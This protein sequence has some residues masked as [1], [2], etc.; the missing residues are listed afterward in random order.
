VA[1]AQLQARGVS[2]KYGA[3]AGVRPAPPGGS[4]ESAFREEVSPRPRSGPEAA[5]VAV[6]TAI[7]SSA[8]SIGVQDLFSVLAR[9]AAVLDLS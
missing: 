6:G 4:T 9:E 1:A 7:S 8:Q 3:P 5:V 2:A